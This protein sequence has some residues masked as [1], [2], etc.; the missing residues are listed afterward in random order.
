MTERTQHWE[1]IYRSK[2]PQKVS[3]YQENPA[4]SLRLIADADIGLDASIID[5]GGGASKLVD[6]LCAAGYSDISVL[7]IS[8]AALNHAKK[9]LADKAC[10]VQWLKQDITA[11]TPPRHYALWHDRAVFHFL[12]EIEDRE[13]YIAVL[14]KAL[15]P[16]GHLIIMAFAIDGPLKCSGLDIVQYDP[17]KLMN[18]L[19]AGFELLE[20]GH[21]NHL[22][23]A[24][25]QQKFAYFRLI[26]I[27]DTHT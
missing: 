19:G 3:W 22:T 5:V 17:D 2:S 1:N 6:E 24:G 27:P 4:L 12:T 21:E 7:D 20:T 15:K 14:K 13:K 26:R 16:G 18:E 25:S 8:G 11:F 23:P 10:F 9:R